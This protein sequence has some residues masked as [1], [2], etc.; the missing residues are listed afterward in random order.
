MADLKKRLHSLTILVYLDKISEQI[1][2][3]SKPFTDDE[4][5]K[6]CMESAA[7]IVCPTQKHLFSK[8]SLS[9]VTVARRTEELVR[10]SKTHLKTVL[11]SLF[12]IPWRLTRVLILLIH[13]N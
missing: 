10:I 4:F 11:L 2:K 1:A 12:F 5:V 6:Q 8:V 13:L 3:K 9:G 7:E